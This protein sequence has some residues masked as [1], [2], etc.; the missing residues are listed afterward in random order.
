MIGIGGR[1]ASQELQYSY[2]EA[3]T[4]LRAAKQSGEPRVSYVDL[5]SLS[6]RHQF[7]VEARDE[8]LLEFKHGHKESANRRLKIL[9]EQMVIHADGNAVCTGSNS[10]NC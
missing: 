1:H 4:T 8:F 9:L 10:S 2:L 6:T 7:P 5:G 3:Q